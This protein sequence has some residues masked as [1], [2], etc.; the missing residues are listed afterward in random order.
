VV[1]LGRFDASAAVDRGLD[2]RRIQTAHRPIEDDSAESLDLRVQLVD[3]IGAS[4]VSESWS[5]MTK[6]RIP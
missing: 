2:D 3:V 4:V 5:L 6:P 1:S